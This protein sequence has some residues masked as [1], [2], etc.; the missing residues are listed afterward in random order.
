MT[1]LKIGRYYKMSAEF[2]NKIKPLLPSQSQKR[3]LKYL[4][5]AYHL[6]PSPLI[7][8]FQPKLHKGATVLMSLIKN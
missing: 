3:R 8:F 1:K 6:I 5:L 2:W 7:A 4:I